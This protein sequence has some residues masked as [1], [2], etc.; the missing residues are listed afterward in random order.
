MIG[1]VAAA[2]ASDLEAHA[3]ANEFGRVLTKDGEEWRAFHGWFSEEEIAA[4]EF[5][6]SSISSLITS[7]NT[8]GLTP[9]DHFENFLAA[10]GLAPVDQEGL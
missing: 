6:S 4:F 7:Q 5:A 3:L 10:N 9:S 1:L 2:L 8:E